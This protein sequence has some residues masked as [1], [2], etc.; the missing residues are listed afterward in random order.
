MEKMEKLAEPS[1][2]KLLKSDEDQLY[3][4]LGMRSKALAQDPTLAGS[5]DIKVMY[6][7][8]AMGPMEDVIAFGKRIFNIWTV[9]A[10]KLVCGTEAEDSADRKKLVD[11][12]GIGET[13]VAV[14]LAAIIVTHLGLAPVLAAVI[15]AII[16]KRFFNPVYKEFCTAWTSNLPNV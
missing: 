8:A 10:N 11:A 5:F 12:L 2:K 13:A 15:A 14:A 4:Q 1:V 9:Q 3:Q 16:I 7:G 6:D